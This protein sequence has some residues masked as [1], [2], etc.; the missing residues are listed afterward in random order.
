MPITPRTLPTLAALL[1]AA[2][3]A[4]PAS[5]AKP[6]P[7]VPFGPVEIVPGITEQQIVQPGPEVIHVVRITP[8]PLIS[9]SPVLPGGS[10]ST[11]G[12]LS[13]AMSARLDAG[14]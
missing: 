10:V 8:G 11:P 7:P 2:A 9:T 1:A 14:A 12:T 13:A 6:P 4:A 5:A 3:M